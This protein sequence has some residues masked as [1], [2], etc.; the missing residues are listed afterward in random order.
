[1]YQGKLFEI[2]MIWMGC[3]LDTTTPLEECYKSDVS[4]ITQLHSYTLDCLE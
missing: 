2:K 3:L 4:F 1:M